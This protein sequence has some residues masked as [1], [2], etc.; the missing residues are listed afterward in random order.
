MNIKNLKMN[1]P[2]TPTFMF[3]EDSWNTEEQKCCGEWDENGIC[4]CNKN[5]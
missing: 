3:W 5:K 4:T 2:D 1:K